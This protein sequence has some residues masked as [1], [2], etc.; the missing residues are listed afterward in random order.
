M[1]ELRSLSLALL[2]I[3]APALPACG[4][5]QAAVEAEANKRRGD[6]LVVEG[7]N[8][9]QAGNYTE[10]IEKL[11]Q[12]LKLGLKYK[13]PDMVESMIGNCFLQLDEFE[14]A[15]EHQ[16]AALKINPKNHEAMVN[17]GA[18]YRQMGQLDDAESMYTQAAALAPDYPELHASLG[19]LYLYRDKPEKAEQSLRRA[20]ELAPN[21]AVAHANLSMVLGHL[22]RFDEAEASLKRAVELGYKNAALVRP[23]LDALREEASSAAN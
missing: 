2:L 11:E 20:I 14:R 16:L 13:Q 18:T 22:G 15:V 21:L 12:A 4:E 10:A 7:A 8:A 17:L 19:A 6:D 5:F 9:Y 3:T 1:L 23:Q